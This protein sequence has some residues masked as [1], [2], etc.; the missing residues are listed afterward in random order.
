MYK[1][2]HINSSRQTSNEVD[3]VEKYAP[4]F[5]QEADSVASDH[6]IGNKHTAFARTKILAETPEIPRRNIHGGSDSAVE[7]VTS[8][9]DKGAGSSGVVLQ[10]T[11]TP[12]VRGQ[13]SYMEVAVRVVCTE[14]YY[15]HR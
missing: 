1:L 13:G 7:V 4:D 15:G 9:S 10:L 12:V 8:A 6:D 3:P 2:F 11:D 5:P 14:N